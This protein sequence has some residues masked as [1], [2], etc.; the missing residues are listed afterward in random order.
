MHRSYSGLYIA[1]IAFLLIISS[2]CKSSS[3][4]KLSKKSVKIT[5]GSF[6]GFAGAFKE[7]SIDKSGLLSM[8][9]KHEGTP[10]ELTIL[11]ERTVTQFFSVLTDLGSASKKVYNPGNMTYFIRLHYENQ[12]PVEWVWGGGE[13]P[14]SQIQ[15]LYSILS[16]MC[17][18]E[19]HPIK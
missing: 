9:T 4:I 5:V 15:S 19:E 18:A 11:N 13:Q 17:R 14:E 2:S 8:K 3:E 12:E 16:K 7:Y 10:R 1:V 6:G